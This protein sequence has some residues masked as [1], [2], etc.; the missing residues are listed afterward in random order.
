MNP[1]ERLRAARPAHLDSPVDGH[2]RD[3]ELSYAMAQSRQ[4][5][6]RKITKPV[7]GLG[8]VS[9]ATA[10]AVVVGVAV[11][12]TGG[13]TPRAPSTSQAVAGGPVSSAPAV[14]L[15]AEQVL[16]T[17]AASSMKAPAEDG[18][19]WYV[20]SVLGS[21]DEAGDKVRYIVH[22]TT[23]HKMWIA[24]SPKAASWFQDQNLGTKPAE[25]AEE[26]WKQDGSP[27]RWKVDAAKEKAG[28]SGRLAPMQLES[29]P[30]KPFGNQ[31]N[32]GDKVVDLAG[33]NTSVAELQAL[34]TTPDELK[35]RLL[36]GYQG[37]GTESGE[38]E[39][40]DSWLYQVTS[41]LLRDMPVKPAVRAAAYK[42]LAGLDGVRSLGE[43][44]DAQGRRGQGVAR[45]ETWGNGRFERQLII[46]PETGVLLTDQIVAVEP[47]GDYAWAKPG[48][49]IWW[50][51]TLE[52]GWSDKVPPKISQP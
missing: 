5:R 41:G 37:H 10:T 39:D 12:G 6:G 50:E 25:G 20:E 28:G 17:A 3:R 23:A 27:T 48:T 46:D 43:V 42:V 31:I 52:A 29:R 11:S 8:L 18:A 21:A 35:K 14:R 13:T 40:A 30:G 7:W 1:M 26:S 19:Y 2:T 32:L 24:R 51:S 44:T 9:A 36:S 33:R 34:P 38:P 45:T 15:S 16:L 4:P 22:T 47:T 49:A